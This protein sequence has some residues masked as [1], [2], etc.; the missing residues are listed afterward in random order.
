MQPTKNVTAA[1][2]VYPNPKMAIVPVK[3]AMAPTRPIS[4]K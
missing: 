2:F 4:V 3:S 1:V